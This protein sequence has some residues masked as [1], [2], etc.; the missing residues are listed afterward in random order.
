MKFESWFCCIYMVV[1]RGVEYH[2]SRS[3]HE[4]HLRVF[5]CCLKIHSRCAKGWLPCITF[6]IFNLLPSA[7]WLPCTVM[8]IMLYIQNRISNF[9]KT[10]LTATIDHKLTESLKTSRSNGQILRNPDFT[11]IEWNLRKSWYFTFSFQL[12]IMALL[13]IL[14]TESPSTIASSFV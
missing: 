14:G 10:L 12:F 6:R 5:G 13:S 4:E 3:E 2:R 1:S 8:L 9:Q 7:F 11:T